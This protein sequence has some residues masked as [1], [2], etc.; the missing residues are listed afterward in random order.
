[1]KASPK[2]SNLSPVIP[3]WLL[4]GLAA[5]GLLGGCGGKNGE[6]ERLKARE[7]PFLDDV[8]VPQGFKLVDKMTEDYESGGQRIARHEYRGF[9]DRYRVRKFYKEQMPLM[10][11]NLLSDQNVKGTITLRFENKYESCTATIIPS[12]LF[13]RTTVRVIVNPFNRTSKEPPKRPVP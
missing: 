1:M 9:A 10:G 11:W 2:Q 5:I 12:G 6:M 3:G 4:V 13:N 8:P 7:T